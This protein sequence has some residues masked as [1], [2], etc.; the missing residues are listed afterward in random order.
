M[1]VLASRVAIKYRRHEAR[2]EPAFDGGGSSMAII[3]AAS[4]P[5]IGR[6]S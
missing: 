3:Q 1:A 4:N 6:A 5:I 2:P